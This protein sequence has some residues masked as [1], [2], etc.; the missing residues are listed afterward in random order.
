MTGPS[1][2]TLC[3]PMSLLRLWDCGVV[4]SG[5]SGIGKSD[6]C[7]SLLDRGHQLV[8]DDALELVSDHGR[9]IGRAVKECGA[10]LHIRGLG[11]LDVR[12]LY[13]EQSVLAEQQVDLVLCLVDECADLAVDANWQDMVLCSMRVESVR[14]PVGS[15]RPLALLVETAVKL[16][17]QKQRGQMPGLEFERH[18]AKMLNQ[19]VE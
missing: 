15:G 14:I 3:L 7:L 10:Y 6:L 17:Q 4:L 9:L 1:D 18:L 2:Q 16:Y 12:Q 8:A 13:G 11:V 19:E 5:V